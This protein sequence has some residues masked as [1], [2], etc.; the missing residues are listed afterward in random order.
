MTDVAV[1]TCGCGMAALAPEDSRC[2]RCDQPLTV[3]LC[4]ECEEPFRSLEAWDDA[5]GSLWGRVH[6]GCC[7]AW[8]C[9]PP[10]EEA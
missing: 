6:E 9:Q 10:T 5:H 8:C 3:E 2:G 7:R 1:M 4:G